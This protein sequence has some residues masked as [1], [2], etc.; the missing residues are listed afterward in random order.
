[1]QND[2]KDSTPFWILG[3]NFLSDY[4]TV[5]DMDNMKVGFA[6]NMT[7]YAE[8]PRTALDYLTI[9]ATILLIFAIIYLIYQV[10]F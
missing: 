2:F 5:F 4:Y 10:C 8:I 7:Y 1:M 9:I 3:D 6:G